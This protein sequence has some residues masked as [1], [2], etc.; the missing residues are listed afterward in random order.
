MRPEI[1]IALSLLLAA[2]AFALNSL[3]LRQ[4]WS[5]AIVIPWML[6]LWTALAFALAIAGIVTKDKSRAAGFSTVSVALSLASGA[7]SGYFVVAVPL[8]QNK[9]AKEEIDWMACQDREVKRVLSEPHL[10][11]DSQGPFLLLENG[12]TFF[13]RDT[14][15]DNWD[16]AME[17]TMKYA[18][19]AYRSALK[20]KK[21]KFDLIGKNY[22]GASVGPYRKGDLGE[23]PQVCGTSLSSVPV[24]IADPQALR[25]IK[26]EIGS[27][28]FSAGAE[29]DCAKGGA[30][31]C[32]AMKS[33]GRMEFKDG[34][35]F[36]LDGKKGPEL[37]F[38][39]SDYFSAKGYDPA[40]CRK[41]I[42]TSHAR[43]G[44]CLNP[45]PDDSPLH[46]VDVRGL[47]VIFLNT[48]P[49]LVYGEALRFQA[50]CQTPRVRPAP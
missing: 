24:E 8:S 39:G 46:P 38:E 45:G 20:G 11:L 43:S 29:L 32:K 9:R 21:L 34:C 1:R 26:H 22:V 28:L 4:E 12:W 30:A 19:A 17:T 2:G 42:E 49:P 18:D 47:E 44:R 25:R 33:L 10:V 6:M 36:I 16:H 15:Y 27:G 35:G 5:I 7:I 31:L 37:E 40:L 50:R 14:P 3:C 13:I 41:E 23:G 48:E